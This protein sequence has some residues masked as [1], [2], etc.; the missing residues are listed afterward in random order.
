MTDMTYIMAVR[1][2]A[3]SDKLTEDEK[4][5]FLG[6]NAERFYG[7]KGLAPLPEKANML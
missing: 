1:F 2:I 6:G 3:E 4:R 7:F 5:A